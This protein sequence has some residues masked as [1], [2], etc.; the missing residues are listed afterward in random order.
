[1]MTQDSLAP[2]RRD[3]LGPC[4]QDCLEVPLLLSVAEFAA[5]ETAAARAG[6]S[7]AHWLRRL[8]RRELSKVRREEPSP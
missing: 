3:V 1:M 4:D 7:V 2:H 6:V 8:I 5:L